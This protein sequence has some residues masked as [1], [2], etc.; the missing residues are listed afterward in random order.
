[1]K[2]ILEWTGARPSAPP[3]AGKP[4]RPWL[5]MTVAALALLL[6]TTAGLAWMLFRGRPAEPLRALNVSILPPQ[7]ASFRYNRAGEG[8]FA[9]S[10]DGA[11][12]AFVT[13]V[14]GKAQL[15][16]R[17]LSE[18]KSRLVPDSDDAFG[19]FWSPDS[20]WI[21]FFTPLKLKKSEVA[22]GA[23]IE[24]CDAPKIPPA[25]TWSTRGIILFGNRTNLPIQRIADVGGSPVP[26]PGTDGGSTPM[27]L[28]DGKRFI[29]GS[30]FDRALWIS[31]VDGD[32]KPR[33]LGELGDWPIYSAGHLLTVYRGILMA[34]PFDASR[35]ELTGEALPVNAPLAARVYLGRLIAD[36]SANAR[37]ILV[38]PSQTDSLQELRWRDR[39]GKVLGS[40]GEPG[41]YYTPRISP[42]GRRVAFMRRDGSNTNLWVTETA[43]Y[44]PERF[45][46][47]SGI[48][49]NPVW[50][51]D[52]TAITFANDASG[53]ANLFRKAVSGV[54]PIDRLSTS[55]LSQQAL[56]WSRDGRFLL[57]TQITTISSQI[58]VQQGGGP[59]L[60]LLGN[61]RGATH[62]QF[63]PGVP[64]WVAYDWDDSG[65]REV[66]V[67]AFEPGKPV[68]TARWE[69]SSAGGTMPRWRGDGKEIFYLSLDGKLMAARVSGDGP[70]FQSSTP[71]LLF[72]GHPPELR[73]P[74]FEYDVTPDGQRFLMIE[75]AK[76]P[77]DQ[78]LTLMTN[79]ATK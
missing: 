75:P 74:V 76:R 52:G 57:F 31:S 38:Y 1:M 23:T 35:G 15:W 3:T 21:A 77:E 4:T 12:L 32:E 45:T 47:G 48:D 59:A 2:A 5:R 33:R 30:R 79:W 10:P 55:N 50:S 39:S 37:G 16:V 56:D 78:P 14:Q 62:A 17:R 41:E 25:G 13:R 42:D 51:R 65:R 46:F 18:A 20:R 8:G 11:S 71:E 6:A 69:I 43:T 68:S 34:R 28:P 44:S 7:G 29:H 19:P 73:T 26:V 58:M 70:S 22:G 27:F 60:S 66:Y 64:R 49:D 24:L 9:I 36:F 61:A 40:L 63:N 72:T 54:G 53:P 67:Q